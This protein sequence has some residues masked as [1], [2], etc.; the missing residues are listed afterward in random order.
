M[1]RKEK[2]GGGDEGPAWLVTFS[3]LMTLLLTFFVLLLSMAVIDERNKLIVLGSVSSSFGIGQASFNPKSPENKPSKVEPGA[4]QT[5]DM[6]PIKDMLWEDMK[7]DLN[8]QE[9]RYVQILSINADVLYNPGETEL[10]DKGKQLLNRIMPQLLRIK[11]PL[12]IAGH[13]ATRRDEEGAAYQVDFDKTK[14]DSTWALSL[15]RS[16]GVYRYL[17]QSGLPSQRL[18][19]ESFGQY[20]PRYSDRTPEERQRNRRVDIVLDKRNAPEIMTLEESREPVRREPRGF[21][22]RDFRFDIEN[23]PG[24]L[25]RR[26][27]F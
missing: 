11:Y 17:V 21:F 12:L 1:A 22:F 16:A 6:A 2:K 26:R 18:T 19:Q 27:L 25:P 8:F 13:T 5:Q 7:N 10:S 24:Q 20:H 14:V 3:D 15:A 9:N 4:M 23:S